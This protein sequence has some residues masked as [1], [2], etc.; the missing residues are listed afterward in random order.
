MHDYNVI[1]PESGG[2]WGEFS[3][4]SVAFIEDEM[5]AERWHL[6]GIHLNLWCQCLIVHS[7]LQ[8]KKRQNC[9]HLLS[10]IKLEERV[11]QSHGSVFERRV[12]GRSLFDFAEEDV[13]DLST[14][15]GMAN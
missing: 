4:I 10:I 15:Q 3:L 1:Q 7:V 8:F 9:L 6:F 13:H 5:V 11:D 14:S 12:F 2:N